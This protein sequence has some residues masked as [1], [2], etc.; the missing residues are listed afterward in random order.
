MFSRK[1][2]LA[3]LAWLLTTAAL[4][5]L[6]AAPSGAGIALHGRSLHALRCEIE[7]EDFGTSV[8]LQGIVFAGDAADGA[9]DMRV[10]GAGSHSSPE[11]HQRGDFAAHANQPVRL[12]I[13]ELR[14]DSGG[15]NAV[16]TLVS[17]GAQYHC[18]RRVGEAST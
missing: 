10:S 16:L 14:K 2:I 17:N 4:A 15:Y 8:R 1:L 7:V 18:D 13:V 5:A 12:G 3:L 9:Y 11:I 6:G